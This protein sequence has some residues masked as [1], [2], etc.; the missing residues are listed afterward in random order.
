[1]PGLPVH[2]QLPEL[3]QTPVHPVGDAIRLRPLLLLSSV[4]PSIRVFSKES[5]L[6]IRW[7]KYWSFSLSI[8]LSSEYSGL[9]S[10][11]YVATDNWNTLPNADSLTIHPQ[12]PKTPHF[13]KT[14]V[15]LVGR[16]LGGPGGGGVG[17]TLD[18][19]RGSSTN[20]FG[21]C[22]LRVAG[23]LR[24]A[25][26]WGWARAAQNSSRGHSWGPNLPGERCMVDFR[27]CCQSGAARWVLFPF[28]SEFAQ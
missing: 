13:N 11:L 14:Q 2:H 10:W 18:T 21:V 23:G 27:R 20:Q 22:S 24:A 19:R 9:I 25:R 26:P 1:M 3:A 6:R 16:P 17:S 15:K 12:R 28:N 7:L 8:S 4:F 5:A